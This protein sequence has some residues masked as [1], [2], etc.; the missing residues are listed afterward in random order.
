MRAFDTTRNKSGNHLKYGISFAALALLSAAPAFAQAAP[1]EPQPQQTIANPSGP[2]ADDQPQT[3]PALQPGDRVIVTARR[4]EEDVQDV[5]IP[6]A[7][8]SEDFLADTGALNIGKLNQLVPS[9][10]FY[11]TN[12]RNT[13]INIRGL[14][15]PFGLTN[16]GIEQGVGL[17]V[18]GVYF[19]RPASAVLDFID[20]E[21]IEVLRGPQGTLYG[22]NTTAGAINVT[23]KLPEFTPSTDVELSYGNL[24][25][26]QAKATTTGPLTDTLAYRLSF[27]GTQRDGVLWNVTD[28]D[29]LND[30]NNIGGRAQLLWTPSDT[31]QVKLSADNTVQRP[32]G[33]AQ[34]FAGV[35]PTQ[36]PLNRQYAA[37]AAF[38]NYAPPSLNPFDRVTDLDT[39]HRSNSDLGG[40]ALNVDWDVGGGTLS[41]ITAW[42]YWIWDPSNDRDFLGLPIRT[43]SQNPSKSYQW[44]QELRYAGDFGENLNYV[45]GAFWFNQVT[46]TLGREEQGS[47]AWRWLANPNATNT[48]L[49]NLGALDGYGQ[50]VQIRS[51]HTSTALFGQL[52]WQVTDQ[53]RILPGLRANFDE[54]NGFY[55][56]TPYGRLD[57]TGL[58]LTPAQVT[59]LRALELSILQ[60]LSYESEG[61]DDNVS[62]Q[63]TVAY[64]ISNNVN[65]YATYATA[66]KTFGLNNNGI[67]VDANN[68]P[69]LDLASIKPEDTKHI[70][71]GL[72]TEPLP[73]VVANVSAYHTAVDDFQVSVVSNQAGTL[74]GYLANAEQVVVQGVEFDGSWRV[75][76]NL[77]FYG[78]IA[79]TDAKYE[80]FTGAPP[81]LEDSGGAV[82]V[83]DASGARLPGVSEWAAS[84]GGEYTLPGEFSKRQGEWFVAADAS[85]RSEFS[86]SPTESHYLNIDGYTLVNLRA[87]FRSVDGWDLFG[88]TRNALDEEYFE[89]LN[90]GGSSSGYYAGLLGDPR[91]YGVTLRGSF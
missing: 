5:P 84:F 68:N 85:Y 14:G 69:L 19:A 59:A 88:W 91:T 75:N 38:Y 87:G 46:K 67:P 6:V 70:E 21:R 42:R 41:A 34:V 37:Q 15:A 66:F 82:L 20:V 62:G 26:F 57:T 3:G 78:N 30:L 53:L 12:P 83:V 29:D 50:R 81:A 28:Q 64:D 23:T 13:A 2:N 79:W 39:P 32:E 25:Y 40:F 74:R 16:D 8:L 58:G 89:M 61:E 43:L 45:V 33:Y 31:L 22:K 49:G 27:S 63:L 76:D 65:A 48:L 56:A 18:D 9:V 51:D 54:K 86:S 47:A 80:K 11:S 71:I 52:E 77:S 1:D 73:G 36:R 72:K 44:S 17:Y 4:V 7:V 55:R 60:P 10:Q 24:G 90:A 35:V